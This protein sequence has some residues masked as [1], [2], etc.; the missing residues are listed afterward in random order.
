MVRSDPLRFVALMDWGSAA[1]GAQ[2]DDFA[3]MP[4]RV[5]PFVLEGDGERRL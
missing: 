3:E 4:I 2:V 1:W 5:V